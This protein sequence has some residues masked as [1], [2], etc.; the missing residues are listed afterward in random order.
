VSWGDL[1]VRGPPLLHGTH[2]ILISDFFHTPFLDCIYSTTIAWM[3]FHASLE[4][5]R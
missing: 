4:S 3:V 1:I 5:N 2:W